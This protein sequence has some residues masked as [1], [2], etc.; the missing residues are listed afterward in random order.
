V[1]GVHPIRQA[2]FS[3]FASHFAGNNIDRPGVDHLVFKQLNR[4]ECGSP[5]RPFLESKV[6]AAVWYCD[7]F[8]NP[9][10]DGIYFGFFKDFWVELKGDVMRFISEFHRNGKLTKGIN[11]TF[12]ALI[13]K[14]DNHQRLND[15]R[16]ISL[17]GMLL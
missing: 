14:V 8:K 3:H 13:P 17:V 11:S 4:E 6:K 15:F 7:S 5:T 2:V 12:I 10:P 9:G 16:L 1:E